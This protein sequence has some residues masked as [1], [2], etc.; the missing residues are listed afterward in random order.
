MPSALPLITLLTDFGTRDYFVASLKGVILTINPDAR[1]VDLSHDIAPHAVTEGAYMLQACYRAF[2]EGTIHLAVVDPGVGSN[3]RPILAK[4]SRYYFVA[5]D[6]G[7]LSPILDDVSDVEIRQLENP[8]YRL[9]SP[10]A[11]FHGRDIFAPAAAWLSRGAVLSSFGPPVC[12]PVKTD[13]PKPT[14]TDEAIAGQIVYVDRFGNLISNLTMRDIAPT[15]AGSRRLA[16]LIR[17]A[18]YTIGGLV[19]SYSEGDSSRPCALINSDGRLEIFLK[20]RSAAAVMA[21]GP[22]APVVVRMLR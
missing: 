18:D 11:T 20:E 9:E 10:G 4:T 15:R 22:G 7:I 14:V 12:D 17:L 21:A 13:W 8:R 5:P 1:I 6:N 3:R 19:G 16:P 2:P